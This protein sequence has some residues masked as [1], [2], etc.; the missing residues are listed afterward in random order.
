MDHLKSYA[1]Q[2]FFD[3]VTSWGSIE[4]SFD[5]LNALRGMLHVVKAGG[6]VMITAP[7]EFDGCLDHIEKEPFSRNNERFMTYEEWYAYF[8][9]V[10]KPIM[11]R[12][13]EEPD[14]ADLF[15]VFRK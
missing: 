9:Q 7:L 15:M 11:T 1:T 2:D 5:P 14:M 13:V 8:S 6:L 3:V 12:K 4:H 10:K